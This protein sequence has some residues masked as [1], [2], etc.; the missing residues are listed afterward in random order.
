MS[1]IGDKTICN[2]ILFFS[3]SQNNSV[4]PTIAKRG[5][6]SAQNLQ[7]EASNE[8][9]TGNILATSAHPIKKTITFPVVINIFF[10]YIFRRL[11]V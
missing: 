9:E 3:N 7:T 4:K 1:F 11:T 2:F 8:S 10:I 6:S 5:S